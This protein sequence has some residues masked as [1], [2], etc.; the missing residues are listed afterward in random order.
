[1]NDFFTL[2]SLLTFTGC[3]AGTNIV[4]QLLKEIKWLKGI[5]TRFVSYFIALAVM[6]VAN[7]INGTLTVEVVFLS[8]VNA[9]GVAFAANGAYDAVH[10]GR[11][12]SGEDDE[13]DW[14]DAA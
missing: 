6:L 7:A 8:I 11:D 10:V 5:S 1:M 13:S 4:T 3:V 9:V 12:M 2:A 14:K